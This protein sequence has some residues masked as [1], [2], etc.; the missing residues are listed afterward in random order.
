MYLWNWCII[1]WGICNTIGNKKDSTS[2]FGN[3]SRSISDGTVNKLQ[4]SLIPMY[5][6]H[7]SRDK[8]RMRRVVKN[9]HDL[10]GVKE[11]IILGEISCSLLPVTTKY[12]YLMQRVTRMSVDADEELISSL[13]L[14]GHIDSS[15]NT[16][17]ACRP[18]SF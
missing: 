6:A 4:T 1:W 9:Y 16:Y 5:L 14:A 18:N 11:N 10:E 12:L 3:G 15:S 17:A 13:K 8:N 7:M 2:G